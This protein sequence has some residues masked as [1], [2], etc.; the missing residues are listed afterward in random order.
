MSGWTFPLSAGVEATAAALDIAVGL[1][2][3]SLRPAWSR[4]VAERAAI[5]IPGTVAQLSTPAI[6]A[7]DGGAGEPGETAP[8]EVFLHTAPGQP[9]VF[10]RSNVE[11]CVNV[12]VARQTR[13]RAVADAEAAVRAV[14]I[15]LRPDNPLTERFLFA[16]HGGP[17]AYEPVTE[18]CRRALQAMPA[19][20]VPEEGP[21]SGLRILPLPGLD[22]EPG[23]DWH[24]AALSD[25]VHRCLQLT[26]LT[27]ASPGVAG[28]RL[29]GVFWRAL[30]RGGVQGGC[31][32][33]D[34]LL[35]SSEPRALLARWVGLWA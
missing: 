11:K 34:S 3:G 6:A 12:I 10:P 13:E 7:F 24:G 2:P 4:V 15:R 29:G 27:L 14:H 21:P 17:S 20:R 26:H 1:A 31:Y 25:S 33:A 18:T 19:Y 23:V 35:A 8:Q 16:G 22:L 28:W 5:S 30:L 9:V 32:V